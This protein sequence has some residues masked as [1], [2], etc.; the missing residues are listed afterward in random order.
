VVGLDISHLA[1]LAEDLQLCIKDIV[2]FATE[3]KS[4]IVELA[5]VRE[6]FN[7]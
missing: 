4:L 1:H 7:R 5:E 2:H 6:C 3:F